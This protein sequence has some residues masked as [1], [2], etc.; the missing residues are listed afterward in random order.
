M[1]PMS[2]GLDAILA[3]VGWRPS[4]RDVGRRV[5]NRY[6]LARV[7]GLREF[8]SFCFCVEKGEPGRGA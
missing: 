7:T 8:L 6:S 3:V 5:R 2:V 4:F 1:R